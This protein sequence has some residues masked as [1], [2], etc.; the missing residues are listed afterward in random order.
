MQSYFGRTWVILSHFASEA[1]IFFNHMNFWYLNWVWGGC[2]HTHMCILN[3]NKGL[4]IYRDGLLYCLF[5][6]FFFDLFQWRVWEFDPQQSLGCSSVCP[7]WSKR[8]I[9]FFTEHSR[10]KMKI[11]IWLNRELILMWKIYMLH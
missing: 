8:L 5:N 9:I 4:F 3:V 7:I 6:L 1:F 2:T 11:G 10:K